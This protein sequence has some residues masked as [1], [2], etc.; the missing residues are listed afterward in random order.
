MAKERQRFTKFPKRCGNVLKN[1]W[2]K[3]MTGAKGGRP[4]LE[5]REFVNGISAGK[6]PPST[7]VPSCI[8][9]SLSSHCELR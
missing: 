1:G 6:R 9:N 2:R 5:M 8:F 7:S 4:R 3:Y